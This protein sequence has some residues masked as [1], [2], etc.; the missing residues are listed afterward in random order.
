MSENVVIFGADGYIG[1]PLAIHL[2]NRFPERNIIIVDNLVTRKLVKSVGSLS[3][4]PIRPMQQRILSYERTSRNNNLVFIQADARDT[5]IVDWIF[6]KYKPQNIVHLAQQRSAPFSMIDQEHALYTQINNL[7][8]NMNIIYSMAR[9][10]PRAHLLKMGSMGEYGTPGI[11]ISEGDLE[12]EKNGKK[13]K[14][15]FPTT[16]QSWY[17]LSKVFD[18]HNVRLANKL[19]GITATDIM[20]GVV[21]GARVDEIVDNSLAT[22]LDFD[23]IWGTLINKY[24][25]QSV[26]LNKL[27]IYGKGKQ[28]R[29]FLSLYDSVNCLTLL[30]DNPPSRGEYRIINQI[31]ETYD[32]FELAERVQDLGREFGIESELEWIDNPRVEKEDHSYEVEH[33]VLPSLGFRKERTL[34]EVI[35]E[36][37]E[38]VIANK[39]RI[40]NRKHLIY[41]TV[42]W[43]TAKVHHASN[44]G[45][46]RESMNIGPLGLNENDSI[47]NELSASEENKPSMELMEQV[48]LQNS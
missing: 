18:S 7:S 28:K 3:L 38:I 26:V 34:D 46:P 33:K 8:T 45:L 20:Q 12:V 27:L 30:L 29:G 17:H 5:N 6:R 9:R 31:D 16:G 42:R 23:S 47:Q 37:F 10:T 2:G 19:F 48:S 11:E 35:R 39:R 41:P 21:Y 36:L 43:K 22:R 32:T 13:A 4:V 1:W 15:A 14:F 25:V 40:A 24:V 44:F